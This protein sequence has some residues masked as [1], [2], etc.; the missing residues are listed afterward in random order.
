MVNW[1]VEHKD[2][3]TGWLGST[4]NFCQGGRVFSQKNRGVFLGFGAVF[5]VWRLVGVWRGWW[6]SWKPMRVEKSSPIWGLEMMVGFSAPA[7]Y[8]GDVSSRGTWHIGKAWMVP[9][10]LKPTA[11]LHPKIDVWKAE[12]FIFVGWP[13]YR[14]KLAVSSGSVLCTFFFWIVRPNHQVASTVWGISGFHSFSRF[15][16]PR[17]FLTFA[18]NDCLKTN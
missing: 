15:E 18:C 5:G 11:S 8:F 12:S 13:I 16:D 1:R 9:G 2:W 14:D 6:W 17:F 4:P 7:F 10:T 3:N